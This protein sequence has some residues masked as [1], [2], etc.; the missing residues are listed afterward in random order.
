MARRQ[1]ETFAALERQ[2]NAARQLRS[3]ILGGAISAALASV[4]GL[5]RRCLLRILA[6]APR[7]A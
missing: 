4:F 6:E 2:M 5:I 7:R 1:F 3:E